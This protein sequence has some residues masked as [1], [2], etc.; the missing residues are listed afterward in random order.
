MRVGGYVGT[1]LLDTVIDTNEG[2]TIVALMILAQGAPL[3]AP[4]DEN[5]LC[6]WK[7]SGHR[8]S[9]IWDADGR[10]FAFCPL[11]TCTFSADTFIINGAT[12]INELGRNYQYLAFYAS[13]NVSSG[14]YLGNGT[15]QTV[16]T[17]GQGQFMITSSRITVPAIP[18]N[19]VNRPSATGLRNFVNDEGISHTHGG[20][21]TCRYTDAIL[22]MDVSSFTVG[23]SLHA[24][25]L[26]EDF[27]FLSI[28]EGI[29]GG[30]TGNGAVPNRSIDTG[31]GLAVRWIYCIN[32]DV[33]AGI[34]VAGVAT[35]T[36]ASSETGYN[37]PWTFGADPH[38]T[39]LFN[40]GAG[41]SPF[42]LLIAAVSGTTAGFFTVGNALDFDY[43]QDMVP[44]F[45]WSPLDVPA[46]GTEVGELP[47]GIPLPDIP[48]IGGEPGGP[49]VVGVTFPSYTPRQFLFPNPYYATKATLALANSLNNI[50]IF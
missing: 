34:E 20:D 26:G 22:S 35:S 38:A 25:A 3:A 39:F 18:P 12:A 42:G 43:N 19:A 46:A 47:G 16:G 48:P 33:D 50:R 8:A 27:V 1:G 45:W 49:Y 36:Q 44:Y 5:C 41:F 6:L 14:T 13:D 32:D 37:G 31:S 11:P 10:G 40:L 7:G 15:S 2:G 29:V 30:F 9:E 17:G 24:N 4:E 23:S 28:E 21:Q